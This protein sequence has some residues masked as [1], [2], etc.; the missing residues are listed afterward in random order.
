MFLQQGD[1]LIFGI[2][3]VPEGEKL[4]HLVLM[5]GEMTGHA[6]RISQGLAE[7]FESGSTKYLKVLSDEAV[8][9]HE[10]HGPITIPKGTYKIG[11]VREFDHFSEEARAVQD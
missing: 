1:C 10:E 5:E 11:R 7:L 6:H 3:V 8:L 9:T 4:N 2:D